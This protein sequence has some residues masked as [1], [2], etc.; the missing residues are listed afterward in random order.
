[1]R[2]RDHVISDLEKQLGEIGTVNSSPKKKEEMYR[3]VKGDLVDE[4][5]AKFIN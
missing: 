2:D 5:I 3:P 4:L 1:M